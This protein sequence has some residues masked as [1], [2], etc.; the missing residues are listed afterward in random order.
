MEICGIEEAID[1]LIPKDN[2]DLS[3]HFN[4]TRFFEAIYTLLTAYE[5][6]KKKNNKLL[7]QNKD[8]KALFNIQASIAKEL[9]FNTNE[10][11]V[12][13]KDEYYVPDT[14][15]INANIGEPKTIEL[16]Y[17]SATKYL[18][19]FDEEGKR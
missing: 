16:K 17:I 6:E 10:K 9:D 8:M 5:K 15:V 11:M 19:K 18:T 1:I 4:N 13:F 2:I 3:N 7:E 12:K 14:M